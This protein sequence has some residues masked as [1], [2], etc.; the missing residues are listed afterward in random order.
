MV[1]FALHIALNYLLVNVVGLGLTGASLAISATFWVSCLMLLAYVMWSKEF[2]ETWKGF[3]TD[4]LNYVLP[5]IKLAMPSAIMVC[6]EYWA[7]ELL[8]LLAGLLPNSTRKHA[9]RFLHDHLWVQ[10][11]CEGLWLG[12]ITGLACQTSV[13]VIITLRTKWSK[14]VDA[15]VKNR[16]DYVA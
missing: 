8:V 11:R 6:L 9:G 15:M 4:A 12:L 7:I 16:D 3:S 1:P 13:M 10:C 14:L 2:D 5:T